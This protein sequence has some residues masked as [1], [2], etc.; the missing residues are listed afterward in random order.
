MGWGMNRDKISPEILR[1][2]ISYDPESGKLFWLTRP[3]DMFNDTIG[4]TKEQACPIWNGRF[5]GK[6]AFTAYDG[7]GYRM[8]LA[9]GVSFRAHIVCWAVH[10]GQW[11][12]HQIDHVNGIRDDNRI[13]NLRDVPQSENGKNQKMPSHNTSGKIGVYLSPTSGKWCAAIRVGRKKEHL[14]TFDTFEQA[15]SA[16]EM[17]AARYQFHQ[18]HGRA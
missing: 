14:G 2:I 1:K 6:E 18:N 11:P 9:F 8:G 16:R 17:A 10:N 7:C 3:V 13:I 12:L 5:A 4:R 15:A